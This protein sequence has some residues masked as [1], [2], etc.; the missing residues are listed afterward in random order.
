MIRNCVIFR[1]EES[2][3]N[4]LII[5]PSKIDHASL[6][7]CLAV[8]EG[9]KKKR[10]E[11]L[12]S[13]ARKENLKLTGTTRKHQVLVAECEYR[14]P[15][16]TAAGA[17]V[18]VPVSHKMWLGRSSGLVISFDAGRK[19]SSIG[20]TLL[21][22]ATTGTVSAISTEKLDKDAFMRV[23]DWALAKSDGHMKRV[24]L[25]DVVSGRT[26]FKQVVLSAGQLESSELFKDMMESS[27]RILNMTFTTPK[28]SAS[29]RSLNCRLTNWGGLTVY[30]Q[31]VLD[32][33]MAELI[34]T[35]DKEL[36]AP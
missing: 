14:A 34:D 32:S 10:I 12:A 22:F 23:R 26:R 36:R 9:R 2:W 19:L 25:A 18:F 3:M 4:N 24:T 21:S 35:L 8:A 17:P 7:N 5:D 16:L 31:D 33:E 27:T 13:M 20:V 6:K 1:Y 15:K 30:S 11:S 29:S 28:L